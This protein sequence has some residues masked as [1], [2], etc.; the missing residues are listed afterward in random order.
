VRLA[1]DDYEL[2]IKIRI[3]MQQKTIS[4]L[5]TPPKNGAL[6]CASELYVWLPSIVALFCDKAVTTKNRLQYYFFIYSTRYLDEELSQPLVLYTLLPSS[7][8][9]HVQGVRDRD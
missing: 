9:C 4:V 7:S 1:L 2:V 8:Y 5:R 6:K 3:E